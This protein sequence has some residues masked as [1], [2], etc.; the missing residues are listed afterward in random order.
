MS[1]SFQPAVNRYV[2]NNGS[3]T[4]QI[5]QAGDGSQAARTR[6]L[7]YDSLSRLTSSV[8]P[9]SGQT[10]YQY[11]ANGNTTQITDARSVSTTIGYDALN[12][13]ISKTYS[14]S[15]P[16]VT[17]S[18]DEASPWG[19]PGSNNTNG[20]LSSTWVNGSLAGSIYIY[21][22][23]GRLVRN[24]QC[25]KSVC[26]TTS[27]PVY[28]SYDY[29]G[30]LTSL[31]YPSGRQIANSY[32]NAGRLTGVNFANYNGTSVNYP[33]YTVPQ[34]T[35]STAWGYFPTGSVNRFSFGPGVSET[36][37]S[38]NRL[39]LNQI[40]ASTSAQTLLSKTYSFYSSNNGDITQIADNMNSGRTQNFGYDYLNRLTSAVTAASSGPDAWNESY[41]IDPWGNMKWSGTYSFTQNFGTNNQ[42]APN[43]GYSY[44]AAGNLLT[45]TFHTY[46]YDAEERMTSVDTSN[47]SYTYS[48]DGTRSRKDIPGD[49]TEYVYFGGQA[50]AEKNSAGDWTDYIF[51]NGQRIAKAEGLDNGLRNYGTTTGSGQWVVQYFGSAAGLNGYTIQ[52][53]DKLY[54][55]QYQIT[56]SKGG[57]VLAFTDGSSSNWSVKDSDGNY[58]NDDQE[59]NATHIRTVDLSSLAGKTINA[60]AVNQEGDTAL[61]SWAIIYE[62]ISLVS[63]DGSVHPIYTGQ[64]SSPLTSNLQSG[65]E[66]GIGSSIDVNRGH[67]I[68]P[69]QTTTY[70]T[71]DHLGSS[72]LITS[73]N[74]YP[75]WSGVFL[76]YGQEWNPQITMNTY[77]FTG[78]EH[79]SESNLEHTWF[80]QYEG[81]QGRWLSPDPYMG[82]MDFANP[83]SFNRYAYTSNSPVTSIDP[84]GALGVKLLDPSTCDGIACGADQTFA[85][86]YT[87]GVPGATIFGN[88]IFD[89]LEGVPGTYNTLDEYG[90]FGFG[91]SPQLWAAT[92]SYIDQQAQGLTSPNVAPFGPTGVT[93]IGFKTVQ[94]LFQTTGWNTFVQNIG[95]E[96]LVTG[97]ISDLFALQQFANATYPSPEAA[98]SVGQPLID[99]INAELTPLAVD[100]NVIFSTQ[101]PVFQPPPTNYPP[102]FPPLPIPGRH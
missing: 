10:S 24:D 38:N 31:T 4:F 75:V 62:Q 44:D 77:K 55:T 57:M 101:F 25:A 35:S 89:A 26:G 71:A 67:A 1:V 20:R 29:A 60:V 79:D 73:G 96:T 91:F 88:D 23:M 52:S 28:A 21:D 46:A 70:Y 100:V 2:V 93:I 63:A 51:A 3:S 78:D 95:T 37:S 16:S 50:I 94:T 74:G 98:T 59:Q 87:P 69:T 41:S 19:V 27:Y 22:S 17:F 18:Y 61:G 42:I 48:A 102:L 82:S 97:A 86:G 13:P 56:G 49:Y 92:H 54:L 99:R 40:T 53:G 11:D 9:E 12:R 66:T 83:Q 81:S 45:D 84:S 15:T 90:N 36:L 80:R 85:A 68:Y 14:D 43:Q 58:L 8:V 76:P 47:G 64:T 72:R 65:G 6:T 5:V 7:T 30:D 34:S 32:N 33:Y 39:M